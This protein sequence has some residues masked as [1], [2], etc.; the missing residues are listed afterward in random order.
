MI[1]RS[2][3]L[4]RLE[5][6]LGER[7]VVT[8]T[9]VGGVGKTRLAVQ[10]A[11][12]VLDRFPDGAWLVALESIRDPDL[13]PTAVAAALEVAE[14]P[15]RPVMETV[16]DAIGS[17]KLLVVLDNCEHLLEASALLVDALLDSCPEVRIVVTSREALGVEGEQSWPTP[18]LTLP[19]VDGTLTVD[20]LGHDRGRGAIR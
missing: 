12:N 17:R 5:G 20:D 6:L 7:R 13:V 10:V 14:R 3:E 1:G 15:G 8:L 11:A 19:P 2:R 4:A 16:C 9:G 18:S